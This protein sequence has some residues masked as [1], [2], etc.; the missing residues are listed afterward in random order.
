MRRLTEGS[1]FSRRLRAHTLFLLRGKMRNSLRNAFILCALV[2][3][4]APVL[5]QTEREIE[6]KYGNPIKV[7]SVDDTIWMSVE[8]TSSGQVCQMTL[9]PKRVS[10]DTV[11]FYSRLPFYELK[12]VLND[13]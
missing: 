10:N 2:L 4:V 13:I 5:G 11:Y 1:Q 3:C 8:Y 12:R 9:F 6:D 7:Y